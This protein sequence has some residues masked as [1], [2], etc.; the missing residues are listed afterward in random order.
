[1]S[2]GALT[3]LDRYL[4]DKTKWVVGSL[5]QDV[6]NDRVAN[7]YRL[8]AEDERRDRGGISGAD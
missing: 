3:M 6:A 1:M 5:H 8:R 7:I 4:V 2:R